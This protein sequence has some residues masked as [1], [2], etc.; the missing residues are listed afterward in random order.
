MYIPAP[1]YVPVYII[2]QPHPAPVKPPVPA[3]VKVPVYIIPQPTPVAQGCLNTEQQLRHAISTASTN[4]LY[5]TPIK[6]CSFVLIQNQ[7]FITDKAFHLSCVDTASP[8]TISGGNTRLFQGA[9]RKAIFENLILDGGDPVS[10]DPDARGGAV[11]ITGG[12]AIFETNVVF[13]RNRANRGGAL[14]V[15]GEATRVTVKESQLVENE[16]TQVRL[17]RTDIWVFFTD[18]EE[19]TYLFF[20]FFTEWRGDLQ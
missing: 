17:F 16:A 13:R 6:V 10:Y 4:Q 15:L 3:P 9:P 18:I 2:P 11:Y 1:F 19:L 8:C 14:Y 20:R 5:P 12:W 7:I